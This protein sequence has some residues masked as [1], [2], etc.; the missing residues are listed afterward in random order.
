MRL[1]RS[2]SAR[3]VY[4]ALALSAVVLLGWTPPK[5][6]AAADTILEARDAFRKKDRWRLAASRSVLAAE[7]SRLAAWADYWELNLRIGE[8]QQS[9]VDAFYTRWPGSY[10]EDRFRNDWLLE[11]GKRRDWTNLAAEYPRF[12]M[13]DDREVKCYALLADYLSGKDVTLQA[14]AA[15]LAQREADEGCALMAASLYQ[16][17]QL[18]AADVWRKARYSVDA[19]RPRAAQQAVAILNPAGAPLVQE[20]YDD[21]V[22][23]LTRKAIATGRGNA[24]MTTLA[25]MRAASQAPEVVAAF[26]ERWE[27]QLPP[28]LA[29]WAWASVGKQA[30]LKLQPEASDHFERAGQWAANAT[31]QRIDWPDETLGWQARAALRTALP[32]S[33]GS[34][35]WTQV[36]QAIDAMTPAEQQDPTWVYW[37]A[38][39]AWTLAE[40]PG[41]AQADRAQTQR[42]EARAA[43]DSLSRQMNF[44]GQLAAE[45]LGRPAA[46]PPAPAPLTAAER[47]EAVRHPGLDRAM[48]LIGLGLRS[49]GVREW[50][51]SIRGM[52]DRELLA[53]AQWACDRELWDRCINTSDRTRSEVDIAQRFPTP[54]RNEVVA[55]AREIDL[56]PAYVY[57]LIRQESRFIMDAR[58]S[59]GASGLMQLMPATARWTARKIGL[60]YTPDLIADRSTNLRLGT[61]YLKLVLDD[62]GGSQAMGAAAYNAGPGRPRR[63]REGPSLDPAI[64]AENIPFTET[65][66]YVKKVL[67]NAVYYAARLHG[68]APS[69]KTRLGPAIGPRTEGAP[70]NKELP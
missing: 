53:A 66:D 36:L 21:P 2:K 30:A 50:N 34:A 23:Y 51:F 37:K 64:W 54:F 45:D 8:L 4:G 32:G 55:R 52:G 61:S 62:F 42:A 69:L 67:S 57:G 7:N 49:E 38:R 70:V 65:R 43:L 33:R 47:A 3:A 15:W 24:E 25:L 31:G 11:L 39:A 22:R 44:Y 19:A 63:W 18:T 28:D 46:M 40:Q 10:V 1:K 58:S 17:R 48:Q 56:D 26:V 14:A 5:A 41:S 9:E 20:L 35:R 60:D 68:G 16:G 6:R 13:N 12:R 27:R 59:A 29:G